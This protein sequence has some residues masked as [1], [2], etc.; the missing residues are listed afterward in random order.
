MLADF[1]LLS[2]HV[3]F[4]SFDHKYQNMIINAKKKVCASLPAVVSLIS[5][6]KGRWNS[7]N[8]SPGN[9][10]DLAVGPSL[11]PDRKKGPRDRWHGFTD[12]FSTRKTATVVSSLPRSIAD[13]SNDELELLEDPIPG[14]SGQQILGH[15]GHARSSD[16]EVYYGPQED[17]A[18]PFYEAYS[19]RTM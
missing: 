18:T 17:H 2:L 15:E 12:V 4:I 6:L 10:G 3:F 5:R 7:K 16:Q 13:I 11:P 8:G 14:A 19:G 1:F 9:S